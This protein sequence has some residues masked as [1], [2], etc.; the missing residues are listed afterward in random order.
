MKNA[1]DFV[2]GRLT[3][4]RGLA[5]A[6]ICCF[7]GIA[8]PLLGVASPVRE[9]AVLEPKAPPPPPPVEVRFG[10]AATAE[11]FSASESG[12]L[13]YSIGEPTDAEQHYLELINRAR[14]N[15]LEEAQRFQETNDPDVLAAYQ[16]FGVDLNL[17][18]AQ[19]AAISPAPPL[20]MNPLL[21]VA[22]RRHS[23]DMA[24]NAFQEHTGSDGSNPGTRARDA[25]YDYSGVGENIFAYSTN[26]WYGHVGFE[27]DWGTSASGGSVGGMQDPPGHRN[28]IH[29]AI[30][31]EI[32]VGVLDVPA[33]GQVGPQLV[34]QVFAHRSGSN[35]F[36]TGVV[37]H[38]LD[39]NG[40]YD[41][42][43]GIGGV[44][45]TIPGGDYYAVTA[46]S[47]GYAVP[48]S[49]NGTYAVE[50]SGA[51]FLE[52]K[53][54]AVVGGRNVKVDAVVPFA[55]EV[56][57]PATIPVGATSYFA[58][59]EVPL[60]EEI[61]WRRVREVS[62]TYKEGAENGTANVL[63]DVSPGYDLI[64]S[65]VKYAGGWAFHLVHPEPVPQYLELDRSILATA[66]SQLRFRSCLRLATED[67]V[68][69]AQVSE[70]GGA[71]WTDV[72]SQAGNGIEGPAT[73]SLV[74]RSLADFAGKEIRVRF[75]Y[76]FEWGG[77]YNF[78]DSGVGFFVDDIEVLSA[79]ELVGEAFEEL[80]AE[81]VFE[82]V[83]GIAGN[84]RV[85]A[86]AKTGG[87]WR[88]FGNWRT[89]TAT[90]A[91]VPVSITRGPE[92][93]KIAP[94]G[95]VTL[96]VFANGTGPLAYQWF[97]NG[98]MVSGATGRTLVLNNATAAT[99]GSYMVWV[100]GNGTVWSEPA[101]ITVLFTGFAAWRNERFLAEEAADPE[102]SGALADPDGRGIPNLLRYAFALDEPLEGR[103]GLPAVEAA[104]ELALVFRRL[105]ERTDLAYRVEASADLVNWAP[106]AVELETIGGGADY[107]LVRARQLS[108]S[109]EKGF[110]R[111]R[112][113]L[114]E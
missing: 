70:D 108:G 99:A 11:D 76:D 82:F 3:F 51:G 13:L 96:E 80:A 25:G 4:S 95:S 64:Q 37:Y 20:A 104:P 79:F 26:T 9:I 87:R 6:Y 58:A 103:E 71:T 69:R 101:Q 40:F 23:A 89:V 102:V 22:A 98:A 73:F 81:E 15:P 49:G 45:V 88:T 32:G 34:T 111:L 39:G 107:E 46:G 42:G 97:R 35:P 65:E 44:T 92:S 41:A 90:A 57:G 19:F 5:L 24:A 2:P 63:A 7:A 60:A 91:S 52:S 31:R 27:V 8:A 55:V 106:A 100:S 43:E 67:Q 110:L 113:E 29:N 1:L 33:G 93:R 36:V 78:T 105:K 50:F 94:G 54:V 84:Y 30:F 38:D 56:A 53:S 14:A 10:A 48:V 18:L 21:T 114:L 74:T 61:R 12:P 62:Y 85:Q 16:T 66:G 86:A 77:Y 17:M 112:V 47:G 72:W 68:A 75:V 59:A 83:P 109:P 28:S